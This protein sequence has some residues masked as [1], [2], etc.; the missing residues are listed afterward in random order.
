MSENPYAPPSA[1]VA[2]VRREE[3]SLDRPQIV[4]IGIWLLWLDVAVLLPGPIITAMKMPLVALVAPEGFRVLFIFMMIGFKALLTWRA[5]Q[6]RNWARIGHLVVL[7]LRVAFTLFTFVMINSMFPDR[8]NN[9]L[10]FEVPLQSALFLLSFALPIA[11]VA[12]LFTGTGS[13]WYRAMRTSR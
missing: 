8:A 11:A 5:G 9:P 10:S 2:D 3:T 6:G 7:I 4:T 1:E 13:D 12:M